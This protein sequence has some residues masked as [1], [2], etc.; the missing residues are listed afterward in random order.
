VKT[1]VFSTSLTALELREAIRVA[2]QVGYG[3][4]L[5]VECLYPKA[6]TE[7]PRGFVAHDLEVLHEL[8]DTT[9]G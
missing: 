4:Y 1:S 2:A 6:K 5:P 3:G 9:G 7:D 8:L